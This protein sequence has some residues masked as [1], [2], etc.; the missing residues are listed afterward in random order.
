MKQL[1]RTFLLGLFV[2]LCSLSLSAQ[3]NA[4]VVRGKV[5]AAVDGEPLI[6]VSITEV[7]A[8]NRVMGMTITNYDGEF[9]LQI[10]NKANKL[11]FKYLG[12]ETKDI[13][14]GNKLVFNVAMDEQTHALTE[15]VVTAKAVTSD[16]R[17]SIPEREVSMAMQKI[18][19]DEF[20]GIQVASIDDALQGRIAGL[21]I[22]NV[23]GE[24]GAGMSMRVRGTTSLNASSEPLIVINDIPYET[25]I[26]AN[27]DFA[28]AN[29]EQYAQLINVNPDD[30][31]S[32]TVLKDAASTAIWGSKGANGVLMITTKK[33][34]AGPTRVSYSYSMTRA[35]QPKGMQMLDGDGY[36]MLM[37]QAYYNPLLDPN[38]SDVPELNYDTN[39]TEYENY[40]NNTDWRA[41][42]SR[43]GYTHD[44][45]LTISGGGEKVTFRVSAAYYN[46]TGT[47]IGQALNRMSLRSNIQYQVSDRILF[48]SDFSY[49]YG[50]NP[51]NYENPLDVAYRKMPNL[52]V[53]AQDVYG[54]DTGVFYHIREDSK[55]QSGQKSLSNPVAVAMLAENIQKSYRTSPVFS[56]SYELLDRSVRQGSLKLRAT[57]SFDINANQKTTFFPKEAT[58]QAWNGSKVNL[59]ERSESESMGIYG[60]ADLT[61]RPV[62]ENT[63]HSLQL[64]GRYSISSS[65]SNSL[66]MGVVGLPSS[67]IQ[68]ASSSGRVTKMS[69]S[70]SESRSMSFSWSFHY[71]YSGKYIVS[72]TVNNQGSSKF[73][74]NFRFGLFPAI[75][76]KWI[77]S[78]EAFFEPLRE[79]VSLL[80]PRYSI[81]I[82]GNE[83]GEAFIHLS[84]YEDYSPG[85]IDMTA[86]KPKN[87]RL[88]NL[89][90]EKTMQNNYGL[91][92]EFLKGKY[93]IDFNYYYKHTTDLLFNNLAIASSSGYS[94]LSSRNVGTMDNNGWEF[95]AHLRELIK[96]NN[97]KVDLNFNFS[98]N[99]NTIVELTD[100][101]LAQYNPEYSYKNGTYLTR[102]QE[103]N[104]AGSIYGFKYLG[105][106]QYGTYDPEH[107]ERTCPI[108]RNADNEAVLDA[109]GNTKPMYYAYGRSAQYEFK[110]G[111]AIYEDINHDGSIDELDIVYLGNSLPKINGGFGLTFR[112]K[113]FSVNTFFNY[114]YGNKVV[115]MA[116][117]NAENMYS[118][119]NQ[120]VTVN[121]RWRKEGDVTNMP[122]ALYQTGY[123]WLGSDRYVEDASFLRFKYLTISY[124][125]PKEL[126]QPLKLNQLNLYFSFQNIAVLTNY[127]GVD[128][129][130]G[131]GGFSVA[132]DN[133]KTPR[134]KDFMFRLRLGF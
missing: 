83:P 27:F 11:R 88:S 25:E 46:Q 2:S 31:E 71:A 123:N 14:I 13:E 130:V 18:S 8:S 85:Y 20:D 76:T 5:I 93:G 68:A 51:K 59:A 82:V 6:S 91:D 111:D 43:I 131:Y 60:T 120:S 50:Y 52:S 116:R 66:G 75:S 124:S 110:A 113:Q 100:D 22:V 106:Y 54:N 105:V 36:T 104:S 30:I 119:D 84:R 70:F 77:L 133:S 97:F 44:N 81:G 38:A 127:S 115:N 61:W 129:E 34:K 12:F 35:K 28:T 89:R 103:G 41:E 9:V 37:K 42:V 114:R 92:V 118:N 134:S 87:M 3:N 99:R 26:D 63:N 33:G 65:S 21:D 79:V 69:N 19:A 45:N 23:S 86:V 10:N 1:N 108:V 48:S 122:R 73:G 4:T 102:I 62:F 96:V 98:N 7:D 107:P 101:V 55:L 128:P 95:N 121:W 112:W 57:M 29:Q 80:S 32:I 53:Y 72:G 78:D 126:I 47:V 40:N 64:Q 15:A 17:F 109:N 90:W 56:L 39:F 24:P 132:Q 125:A 67:Q 58:N 49:S 16:G 94:T 117:M 74:D